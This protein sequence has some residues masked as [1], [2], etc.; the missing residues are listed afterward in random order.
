[1][2]SWIYLVLTLYVFT[3]P[4]WQ[5]DSKVSRWL[6]FAHHTDFQSLYREHG[7]VKEQNQQVGDWHSASLTGEDKC[8]KGKIQWVYSWNW[9]CW[10]FKL[11]WLSIITGRKEVTLYWSTHSPSFVESL[12]NSL[13]V[14]RQI[15]SASTLVYFILIC[16]SSNVKQAMFAY[17]N[18][19]WNC[20]WNQSVLSNEVKVSCSR[21]QREPCL[22]L[23]LTT[24]RHQPTTSQP[25]YPLRHVA[26]H[27]C[28][29]LSAIYP[30][31]DCLRFNKSR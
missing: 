28:W 22:G 7:G 5:C 19:V 6:C 24:D 10:S 2:Y 14:G 23:K 13:Q 9:G 16:F 25:C 15:M 17:V 27:F 20:Y 1:M 31:Q 12:H 18:Q 21:N 11:F 8:T 30:F 29:V 26:S 4:A 3:V